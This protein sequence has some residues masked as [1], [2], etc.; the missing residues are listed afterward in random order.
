MRLCTLLAAIAVSSPVVPVQA[1]DPLRLYQFH[2]WQIE[3]DG[4]RF[5]QGGFRGGGTPQYDFRMWI[6]PDRR[7]LGTGDY[8]LDADFVVHWLG[9]T[10]VLLVDV[11]AIRELSRQATPGD[12][13]V[14]ARLEEESYRRSLVLL[15]GTSAWFYP[16]GIPKRGERGIVYEVTI[17]DS[18]PP[19][20]PIDKGHD[21]LLS[22]HDYGV[23]FGSRLHRARIRLEIGTDS[24]GWRRVFE[25]QGLT[26]LP[27]RVA[28]ARDGAREEILLVE[29]ED[30]EWRNKN[31]KGHDQICW[32]WS[33][34]D[35]TT[36]GG[37]SCT[38]IN[39]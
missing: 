12:S 11:A 3:S 4:S 34:A 29:L 26:R 23:E 10:T 7:I 33:W 39:R 8:R 18:S 19:D 25:G 5:S 35:R 28:L 38:S 27:V 36:R 17:A 32:R 20:M 15:P 6:K 1:Q 9:D 14:H 24:T 30:P 16:F 21:F 22:G 2:V 37:G 31:L 13:V